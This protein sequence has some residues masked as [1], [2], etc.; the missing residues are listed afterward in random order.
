MTM[1][2]YITN[3]KLDLLVNEL[4]EEYKDLLIEKM[5]NDYQTTDI[6]NLPISELLKLDVSIKEHLIQDKQIEKKKRMYTMFSSIGLMYSLLG[7]FLLFF[8]EFK[9]SFSEEPMNMLALILIM[10]GLFISFY[11]MLIKNL[12]IKRKPYTSIRN[13]TNNG[14]EYISLWKELEGLMIQVSPDNTP[15]SPS[16]LIQ[17]LSESNFISSKDEDAIRNLLKLRNEAVHSTSSPKQEL[18]QEEYLTL[19]KNIRA[20]ISKLNDLA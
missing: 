3:Q 9:Y 12:I 4:G 18:T 17:Y 7:I 13:N 15:S 6:D 1:K 20:I 14:Y 2:Y 11:G 16:K 10:I 5:L 19:V 8:Q